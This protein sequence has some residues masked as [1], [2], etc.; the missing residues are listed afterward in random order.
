MSLALGQFSYAAL[1]Y[2]VFCWD[3]V[4]E[5]QR[6]LRTGKYCSI[7]TGLKAFADGNH[8]MDFATTFPF[9]EYL[10]CPDAIPNVWG[11]G[12]P[13]VGHDVWIGQDVTLMSG[14][15]IGSGAVIG[16]GSVVTNDVPPY[17]VACGNPARVVK[18]RFDDDL[19]KQF[20]NV[21]WWDLPHELILKHLV[22]VADNPMEWIKQAESLALAI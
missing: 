22:P 9:K 11:K 20:L 1:P 17:A 10:N 12:F 13:I 5:H 8:R 18:F 3:S 14:V 19:I 6:V 16:Y 15:K 7:G 21:A 4:P 2:T